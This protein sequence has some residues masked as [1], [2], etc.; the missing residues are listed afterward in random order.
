MPALLG[1]APADPFGAPPRWLDTP[2]QAAA[3][4]PQSPCRLCAAM[5]LLAALHETG[6][7]PDALRRPPCLCPRADARP[8]APRRHWRVSPRRSTCRRRRR[9][10]W[11][12]PWSRGAPASGPSAGAAAAPDLP[13]A[14]ADGLLAWV[15]ALE[16]LPGPPLVDGEALLV[17]PPTHELPLLPLPGAPDRRVAAWSA[18]DC[19]ALGARVL[20]LRGDPGLDP[21]QRALELAGAP[22]A[23][24]APDA[25]RLLLASGDLAGLPL[26]PAGGA[27]DDLATTPD[28]LAALC[29]GLLPDDPADA[30]GWAALGALL[31]G[32]HGPHPHLRTYLRRRVGAAPVPPTTPA[33]APVL[34]LTWGLLLYTEQVTLMRLLLRQEGLV[35]PGESI[36]LEES[37]SQAAGWASPYAAAL[38]AGERVHR[39]VRLKVAQPAAFLAA[40]LE[41]AVRDGD[42]AAAHALTLEAGRRGIELRPPDVQ[43]SAAAFT[44]E[45]RAVR[46]GLAWSRATAPAVAA[47][48]AARAGQPDGRFATL[49]ALCIAALEAAVPAGTLA[50]LIRAGACDTLG[51]RT[52]LLAAL[53]ATL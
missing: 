7:T 33:L 43:V 5:T 28:V 18:S 36:R 29:A 42:T 35:P 20:L 12:R 47:L 52:N 21:L 14:T 17:L 4:L 53:P 3:W 31:Y 34:G 19:L 44:L 15:T 2:P 9:Q 40:A 30:P 51:A 41:S 26:P 45:D 37:M 11:A 6:A 22:P 8:A 27:L 50:A 25:M 23:G 49:A 39:A 13:P 38:A 16:T 10:R 24:V 46:W 48:V 32:P 1:L